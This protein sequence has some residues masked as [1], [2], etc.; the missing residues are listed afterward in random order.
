M[1]YETSSRFDRSF[2]KF[3]TP[4]RTAFYKQVSFLLNDIRHPSLRA[5]KVDESGD[6]WQARVNDNVRFH[7]GIVGDCYRLL[8]IERHPD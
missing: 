2:K 6:I 1:R 3:S 5:K 4:I 7:F 8:D